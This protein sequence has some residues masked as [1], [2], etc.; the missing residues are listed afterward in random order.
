[1]RQSVK[2]V[3]ASVEEAYNK[4]LRDC[5]ILKTGDAAVAIKLLA[6]CYEAIT[7]HR[8]RTIRDSEVLLPALRNDRRALM[9]AI[10]FVKAY[11][12]FGHRSPLRPVP[13]YELRLRDAS[14]FLGAA[15]EYDVFIRYKDA[16]ENGFAQAEL[17]NRGLRLGFKTADM[18]FNS[19]LQARDEFDAGLR[20]GREVVGS[21]FGEILKGLPAPEITFP[22]G[23]R[24]SVLFQEEVVRA[25]VALAVEQLNRTVTTM[26]DD[27]ITV[28]NFTGQSLKTL[29]AFFIGIAYSWLALA[30]NPRA[31]VNTLPGKHDLSVWVT[32][33]D[34]ISGA[35]VK[36]HALHLKLLVL[37]WTYPNLVKLASQMLGLQRHVVE[38]FLDKYVIRSLR[39]TEP[40]LRSFSGFVGLGP[41][42]LL[43]VPSLFHFDEDR[44]LEFVRRWFPKP[45]FGWIAR[46]L[47]EQ[48]KRF[49][50]ELQEHEHLRVVANKKLKAKGRSVG[51]IDLAIY[52]SRADT[53]V[54]CEFKSIGLDE[55]SSRRYALDV[56]SKARRQLA[57]VVA[58][59]R[60]SGP[61]RLSALLGIEPPLHNMPQIHTLII[62]RRHYAGGRLGGVPILT[63]LSF[64]RLLE[65]C[66]F[67]LGRFVHTIGTDSLASEWRGCFEEIVV[68]AEIADWVLEYATHVAKSSERFTPTTRW[69]GLT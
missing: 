42:E 2:Q 60:E 18:D 31:L 16:Y 27:D 46:R 14:E 11:L 68:E 9:R 66:A 69:A 7:Q 53:L 20:T 65:S 35:S 67:D 32:L 54:C 61:T 36:C 39:P 17:T 58:Y 22:H 50:Q 41:A 48:N 28:G 62:T 57:K 25:Y 52:D 33:R 21:H 49:E 4:R 34:W 15:F 38:S 63:H 44:L 43:L 40:D 56:V 59:L 55:M 30:A 19:L 45:Y 23:E 12:P 10:S 8:Q 47:G 51:D 5:S 3:L 29:W 37:D 6:T 24:M 1:M 26:I 64:E 13:S